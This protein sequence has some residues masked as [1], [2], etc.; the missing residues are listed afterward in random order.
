[1][2]RTITGI[3]IQLVNL[4][5]WTPQR[6]GSRKSRG[7]AMIATTVIAGFIL[8][9]SHCW[10]NQSV[11]KVHSSR[12]T[13]S[14][15]LIAD[16]IVATCEHVCGE[17]LTV[18][19]GQQE[20]KAVVLSSDPVSDVALLRV[21]GGVAE[22][23]TLRRSVVK[24]ETVWKSGYAWGQVLRDDEAVVEAIG[25]YKPS[26]SSRRPWYTISGLTEKG[27]S[28]GP[29]WD[30]AG[31]VVGLIL[32]RRTDLNET[33]AARP[34]AIWRI[35][36]TVGSPQP[37]L[38]SSIRGPQ[39]TK[40]SLGKGAALGASAREIT[41]G[42]NDRRCRFRAVPARAVGLVSIGPDGIGRLVR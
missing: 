29:V 9:A 13:G 14:G 21:P 41:G 12:G 42:S 11:C 19:F 35:L 32:G 10:A 20:H 15:V 7:P 3:V 6:G 17:H 23:A 16:G 5:M 37:A 34:R 36:N 30:S 4:T 28:G 22:P 27:Q 40:H 39:S 33:A 18:Q 8:L 25:A 1:M 26:G 38:R 24:G 2:L 31:R